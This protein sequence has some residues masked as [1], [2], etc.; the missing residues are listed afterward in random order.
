MPISTKTRKLNE[1]AVA[2]GTV[3]LTP[4]EIAPRI[5]L[6]GKKGVRVVLARAK[7]G[8]L[9]CYHP[10]QRTY[11]FHWPTVVSAVFNR[12]AKVVR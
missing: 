6:K 12:S 1:S 10:N 11:L 2:A 7:A 8:L 9:P 5:G 4:A 3:M